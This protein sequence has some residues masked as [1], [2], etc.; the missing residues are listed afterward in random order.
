MG[1]VSEA[2]IVTLQNGDR[3]ASRILYLKFGLLQV[4]SAHTGSTSIEW[5][6]VRS[7]Q[8]NYSFRVEKFGGERFAG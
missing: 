6:S 7:I 1:A 5:P 4:N 8:S 2:D 3:L